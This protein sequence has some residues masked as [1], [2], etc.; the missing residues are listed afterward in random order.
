MKQFGI[1]AIVI[2]VLFIVGCTN[3]QASNVPAAPPAT[4]QS[5]SPTDRPA[6]PAPV[7]TNPQ[8][9]AVAI[10]NFAF[11]PITITINAGDTVIW[12]NNDNAQHTVT[13]DNGG[14]LNSATI[15]NGGTYSHAFLTPGTYAYHCSI[16]ASMKGTVI[17]Q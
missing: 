9:H 14:A 1:I 2:G 10:S 11:S 8:T 7:N 13:S 3:Y 15:S 17:V 6:I 5:T 16:H 4:V 12:T